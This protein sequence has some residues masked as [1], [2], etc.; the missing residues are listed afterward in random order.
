MRGKMQIPNE[1]PVGLT[2]DVGYQIGARRTLPIAL[3]DAW[4]LL[5]SDAGLRLW[6]GEVS[7]FTFAKGEPY[8][9]ADGTVGEGRVYTHHSH[10]RFTWQPPGWE[11]PSTIQV[12]LMPKK[13]R[14]VFA[15]HQEH[16]PDSASRTTRRDAFI[17]ALD[18]IEQHLQ[19][20]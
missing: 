16:L 20:D 5:F 18:A 4:A 17:A 10:V 14:T 12:R 9:L 15:F 11:R 13:D 2:R 8:E 7:G 6:L 1:R 3:E 19:S